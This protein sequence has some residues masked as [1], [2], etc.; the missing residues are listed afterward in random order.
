MILGM[1]S[2]MH[3]GMVKASATDGHRKPF[4]SSLAYPTRSVIEFDRSSTRQSESHA[5]RNA[6]LSPIG[7]PQWSVYQ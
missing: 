7:I 1:T 2:S 6:S 3:G 4:H 5:A